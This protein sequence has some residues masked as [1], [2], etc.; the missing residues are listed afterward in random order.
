MSAYSELARALIPLGLIPRGGFRVWPEDGLGGLSVVVLVGNAGPALWPAFS[1]GRRAEPDPLDAWVARS[2]APVARRLGA[3]LVMPNDGPPHAPFQ[4]WAM[5]AEPVYPSP[6][7]L[8]IHPVYGLW[9]AYRAALLFATEIDLPARADGV[10]PCDTCP[11][12]PCL[13][14]CPVGAFDGI[15]YDVAACRAHAGGPGGGMC[16]S[17]GCLA[18]HACPVG[19]DHAYGPAQ[20]A[21]HMAAFLPSGGSV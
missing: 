7:G 19:R 17:G 21:Y 15:G 13:S 10:S 16:R 3:R 20:Q 8:L 11:D 5:R 6:L 14:A 2:L 12:R 18:R 1:A 9:H 4:R